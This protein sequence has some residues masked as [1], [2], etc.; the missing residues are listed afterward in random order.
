VPLL[1]AFQ[2][3][4]EEKAPQVLPES[5]LGKAIGYARNQWQYLCRYVDDGAA[6]R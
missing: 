5:L 6:P 1:E 2:A 4:L 3:W